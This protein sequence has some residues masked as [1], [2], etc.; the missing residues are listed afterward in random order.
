MRV[1]R[2]ERKACD[3]KGIV[4]VHGRRTRNAPAS[5]N[6]LESH[7]RFAFDT[8]TGLPRPGRSRG[9]EISEWCSQRDSNP[10]FSLE[11]ATS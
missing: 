1:G 2:G 5:S 7:A 10:C 11:R 6:A 8:N 4:R 9:A 3:V